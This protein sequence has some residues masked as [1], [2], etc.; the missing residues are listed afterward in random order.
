M[1]ATLHISFASPEELLCH[2]VLQREVKSWDSIMPES[3]I[4]IGKIKYISKQDASPAFA[5]SCIQEGATVL[6]I[7][8]YGVIVIGESAMQVGL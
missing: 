5:A 8:E 1:L 7:E 4:V 2:G 6:L 3:F